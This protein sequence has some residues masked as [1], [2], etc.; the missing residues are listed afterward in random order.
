MQFP[1]SIN[2][3]HILFIEFDLSQKWFELFPNSNWALVVITEEKE[4]THFDEIVR[5]A[6]DKNVGYIHSVGK[7]HNFIHELA[8]EEIVFREVENEYLPAH[9]IITAGEENF[10]QGIWNGIYLSHHLETEIQTIFI[11]D[12]TR[13]YHDKVLDLL[14]RF[15]SG[16]LP[17]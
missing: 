6:I 11:F 1:V 10:E 2:H 15:E 4:R 13:H 14:R 7:Q 9:L 8:D 16:Y 17:K 5:K 3:K 12:T